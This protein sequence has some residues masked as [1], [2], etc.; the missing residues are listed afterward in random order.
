MARRLRGYA[1]DNHLALLCLFLIL[2]GGTAYAA[3]LAKNSV[4]SK[5]I[6]DGQVKT[7]DLAN[8][9]VI[10]SKLKGISGLNTGQYFVQ[11]GSIDGVPAVGD[12]VVV[13]EFSLTP[14]CNQNPSGTYRATVT[15]APNTGTMAVHSEATGGASNASVPSPT[16]ANLIQIGPVPNSTVRSGDFGAMADNG[17]SISSITGEVIAVTELA[18]FGDCAFVI[19]AT[20]VG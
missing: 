18:N 3:G 6:K 10:S 7:A 2:G 12:P 14:S 5:Q 20:P 13:G 11:D 17:A 15:I 16:A 8:N 4:K 9:S 1:K 19:S